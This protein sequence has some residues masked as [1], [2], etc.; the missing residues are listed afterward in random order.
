MCA[1]YIIHII[2]IYIPNSHIA[3]P[4]YKLTE[5]THT[6]FHTHTHAPTPTPTPSHTH[7]HTPPHTKSYTNNIHTYTQ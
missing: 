7:P 3:T 4:G 2:Y 6:N 5:H 1:I